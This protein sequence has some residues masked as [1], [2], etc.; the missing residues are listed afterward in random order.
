[1][2]RQPI[3]FCS[4]VVELGG[5]E[6]VLLD[7]LGALDRDRWAP[8]LAVPHAGPLTDAAATLG[9]PWHR[10]PIGGRTAF[11]KACSVPLAA[12]G[13]RRLA[14]STGARV[15]VAT[16]MIAGYA[17]VLAQHRDL[18]C[19]WHLHIVTK[20]HVARLFVR[21]ARAVVVPSAA[22][23]RAVGRPD[24]NVIVNGIGDRFFAPRPDGLRHRLGVPADAPLFG[25]VGRLDPHKGHDVL[26]AAFAGLAGEPRAHLAIAGGE[27][28]ADGLARVGGYAARLARRIDELGLRSRVHALGHVADTAPLFAELDAVVVPS[29]A[30]ESAPRTIAEAHAAGCPV[31]ASAIGG[32]PE[33]VTDGESGL[34]VPPGDVAALGH[35]LHRLATEPVLRERLR[36]GGRV[37]AADCR[38]PVFAARCAEVFAR[39]AGGSTPPA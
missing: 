12:R 8:H 14:R 3:L 5:A 16:S 30:P 17:A 34:L 13:L 29:T 26:L 22:G 27:L 7:L 36:A 2:A 38:L 37:R 1:M 4:H 20:S 6:M 24:A 23:A 15:V 11:G 33:R 28:F 9:V 18:A 31:L 32:V 21:R 10:L 19:V 25:I 35:A 39:A